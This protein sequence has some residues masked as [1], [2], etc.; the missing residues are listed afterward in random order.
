MTLTFQIALSIR[1]FYGLCA[2]SFVYR[3]KHVWQQCQCIPQKME[4]WCIFVPPTHKDRYFSSRFGKATPLPTLPLHK[5]NKDNLSFCLINKKQ[6]IHFRVCAATKH[7]ETCKKKFWQIGAKNIF[8]RQNGVKKLFSTTSTST[9]TTNTHI[10]H[11]HSHTYR[12]KNSQNTANIFW[13][14]I[15]LMLQIFFLVGLLTEDQKNVTLKA[16][17]SCRQQTTR[18]P[19]PCS[20]PLWPLWL[21]PTYDQLLSAHFWLNWD[22]RCTNSLS[23][24]F[25][26]ASG[27]A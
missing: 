22:H 21:L 6:L 7:F 3:W 25:Y 16:L 15:F 11:T 12:P 5:N 19:W 8:G 10:Q 20:W 24:F 26:V 2:I 13:C 4:R 23:A 17:P 27:A 1:A 14:L 18:T 9:T